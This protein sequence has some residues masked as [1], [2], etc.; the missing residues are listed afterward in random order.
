M[1][2]KWEKSNSEVVNVA[3]FLKMKG[4]SSRTLKKIRQGTAQ[5]IVN[6]KIVTERQKLEGPTSVVLDFKP[7]K[8][9]P[10]VVQSPLPFKIISENAHFLAVNKTPDIA[11]VP[12]PQNSTTTLANRV[13]W[14]AQHQTPPFVSHILTRLDYD[15][16]GV[17]LF[18]KSNFIQ[19][20][21]QPQ[22]ADHT[23]IKEY[24]ALVSGHL[25]QKHALI[26]FP[27]I[28]ESFVSAR[29]I[30][31]EDGKSAQ[32]EYWVVKEF[33]TATL[34][35]ILLHTGRTHQIR[36][37]FSYLGHPLIGDEL[38]EGPT[39]LVARQMLHAAKVNFK[40]PFTLKKQIFSAP[41]SADFERVMKI[42]ES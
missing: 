25:I 38:Y 41:L 36:A 17:V 37:H 11:S 27:L 9:D 3:Q 4:I 26:D 20:M 31:R 39:Q 15:T 1:Q 12:G 34:V 6:D 30:V 8:S 35:R 21:T 7:E 33:P 22:I 24:Y 16:S 14:Y 32:T 40:D 18:A 13:L 10:T 23:M 19:S 5:I 28:K 2:F 29:R 42:L